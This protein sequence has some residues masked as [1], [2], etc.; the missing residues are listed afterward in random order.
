ST[1]NTIL[2]DPTSSNPISVAPEST[3]FLN[4]TGSSVYASLTDFNTMLVPSNKTI[5]NQYLSNCKS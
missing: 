4:A 1:I 3:I 2:L 5:A